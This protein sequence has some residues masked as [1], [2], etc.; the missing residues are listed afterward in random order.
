MRHAAAGHA[1]SAFA[2]QSESKTRANA[3]CTGVAPD[4][5]A[6]GGDDVLTQVEANAGAFALF[7]IHPAVVFHPEE[8]LEDALAK[9]G[10]DARAG[11]RHG[12]IQD[13]PVVGHGILPGHHDPHDSS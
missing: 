1:A 3:V 9:L 11:I 6:V 5:S 10:W 4:V 7:G 12:K 8:L 13:W 2:R